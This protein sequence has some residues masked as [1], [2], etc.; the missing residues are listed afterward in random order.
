MKSI[1]SKIT[2]AFLVVLLLVSAALITISVMNLVNQLQLADEEIEVSSRLLKQ[3]I[4][5]KEQEVRSIAAVFSIDEGIIESLASRNINEMEA[6]VSPVFE[7][8]KKEL[9]LSVFEVGDKDGVVFFRG[10]EPDKFGDNKSDKKTIQAALNGEVI[11]GTETGSSGIAIRAFAPIEKNNVIIGSLQVGLSDEFFEVYKN[12]SHER[13][14]LFDR[15]RLLYSTDIEGE[16]LIS[17]EEDETLIL[18]ALKGEDFIYKSTNE[19]AHY[20]PVYEP[21]GESV[22]GLF[23]VIYDKEPINKEIIQSVVTNFVLLTVIILLVVAVLINFKRSIINPLN[24]MTGIIED[25]S[26]N[27]FREKQLVNEKS[28]EKRDE[29][30]KLSRA[31]VRLTT[32]MHNVFR[33][34]I[35]ATDTV[36]S[37]SREVLN[38]S[39]SNLRSIEEINEGFEQFTQGIQEQSLEVNNSVGVMGELADYIDE[40]ID[41]SSEIYTGT[42]NIQSSYERSESEL[43]QMT[44][45]FNNSLLTIKTLNNTVTELLGS[46][47]EIDE[48][49]IVIQSIAEQT[50]LLALNASI[51]AARAGEHG[52]GFSVVAEQVRNLSEESTNSVKKIE[53][54]ISTMQKQTSI[55]SEGV[56]LNRNQMQESQ[57]QF[58]E[59]MV[60]VFGFTTNVDKVVSDIYLIDEH[61]LNQVDSASEI[62]NISTQIVSRVKMMT[63]STQEINA[64]VDEQL[65]SMEDISSTSNALNLLSDNL[66]RTINIFKL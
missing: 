66:N 21:T 64:Q 19:I 46:S 55:V 15:E 13:L 39:E 52:R 63:A 43:E 5:T 37:N 61:I 2:L 18:R 34:L 3:L 60:E 45:S 57:K 17:N 56:A 9:G 4:E 1:S 62:K 32:T 20:I 28:L 10:H 40:S 14:D 6:E 65:T 33:T 30:G 36:S 7:A 53:E 54:M 42:Q 58:S 23:K 44:L 16:H 48:I 49:L 22:I 31:I 27:D 25:M 59:M 35:D 47:H 24:E 11:A 29:T 12:L 8:Y 26:E 51:E 50:N 41:K 38:A